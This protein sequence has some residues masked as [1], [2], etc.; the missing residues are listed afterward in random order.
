MT[1]AG[2]GDVDVTISALNWPAP[3]PTPTQSDTI[4][5]LDDALEDI[6]L[7]V[8]ANI[9]S[10][11]LNRLASDAVG[12]AL[13]GRSAILHHHDMAWQRSQFEHVVDMPQDDPAWS[14][15]TV[16]ECTRNELLERGISAVTIA[17]G[18]DVD[19]GRGSRAPTRSALR[20]EDDELV[21]LHPVRAIERKNIP[22][23]LELAEALGATYWLTGAAEEGYEAALAELFAK[24]S[25]RIIH[26]PAPTN[27]ADAYAAADVVAFPSR[28][29]GFGNPLIEAAIH[30]RPLAI[31]YYPVARDIATLGF[32]WFDAQDYERIRLF[33]DMD[34]QAPE[35]VA[36]HDHNAAIARTHFS[37][38]RV[39]EDL[40]ELL[41]NMGFSNMATT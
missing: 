7:V 24:A 38:D 27:M 2:S 23:A 37:H 41:V 12:K 28:W 30:R 11:P 9:C 35:V 33:L 3:V 22:A 19:E 36:L 1:I 20:I 25:C 10:L 31:S 16:N 18:F 29:E 14:H 34:D 8:V 26:A 5:A 40:R 6:D 13:A 4:A 21:V 39:R 32:E 15:V 17:N